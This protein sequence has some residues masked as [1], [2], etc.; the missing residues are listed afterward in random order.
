MQLTKQNLFSKDFLQIFILLIFT[1]AVLALPSKITIILTTL[2]FIIFAFIKPFESILY[3]V[4]YV[5]IRPFLIEVN[6]GMKYIGDIITFILLVKCLISSKFDMK[7]LLKFKLFE[8]AFFIFLIFGALIGYFNGV[9]VGAILFQVRTFIIMYFI[10]FF[11]SRSQLPINFMTKLAWTGVGL[12]WLISLHGIVEKIS[13]RQWLL[14]Y[15]WK[16]MVLSTENI[17]RIYGLAGN[18]NSLALILMFCIISVFVL[19]HLFKNHEHKVFLNISLVLFMGIFIL[20]FS[21]GTLIS[22]FVLGVIYIFLSRR[23]YLIKQIAISLVASV[24]L[25]YFPI[26]GGV[27]LAQSMGVEAPDGIAGGIGDRFNQTIDEKNIELMVSNGRVFYIKKGFEIFSDHPITGTGF[28]TFGGAA[29][30]SYGSPIYEDYGIDLS[31]YYDN[32][33]YSDNQYI[34]II[35][36]TGTIGVILFGIFLISMVLLFWKRKNTSFG[37]FMIALWISTGCSGAY[38]NI[39]ELKIYTLIFFIIIGVFAVQHNLYKQYDIK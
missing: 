1:F 28:G 30:L 13:I 19:K 37:Q 21:R 29:T 11:L 6:T 20:T 32:K 8:W 22:A 16:H 25:V 15:N 4:I 9:S 2:V 17:S 26:I 39:W 5:A 34:Q 35:A 38:Y 12:G 10:Y 7:N 14:P 23:F 3:L 33:I 24:L 27:N 18:P 36:E 31:I